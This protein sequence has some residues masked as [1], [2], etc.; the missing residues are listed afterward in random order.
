MRNIIYSIAQNSS[1]W[2]AYFCV[3]KMHILFGIERPYAMPF[4][5]I[6]LDRIENDVKLFRIEKKHK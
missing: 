6:S 4:Y 3:F 2:F 5:E 1:N